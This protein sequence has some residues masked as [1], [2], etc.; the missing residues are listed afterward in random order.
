MSCNSTITGDTDIECKKCIQ[1]KSYSPKDDRTQ[2]Q[3][4]RSTYCLPREKVTGKCTREDDTTT[5]TGVCEDGFCM[6]SNKTICQSCSDLKSEKNRT[7]VKK[8]NGDGIPNKDS[9]VLRVVGITVPL[10]AIIGF[11]VLCKCCPQLRQ[12]VGCG[13]CLQNGGE[14]I[15]VTVNNKR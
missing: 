4:C 11:C 6:N 12:S 2:C 8:P 9:T 7:T 1:G 13:C 10:I 15:T 5:C 14:F 3:P